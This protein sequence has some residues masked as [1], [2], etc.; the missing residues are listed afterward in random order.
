MP[1]EDMGQIKISMVF[2][3]VFELPSLRNAPKPVKRISGKQR[4]WI[5]VD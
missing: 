5:F 4:F 2:N 1:K 3:G